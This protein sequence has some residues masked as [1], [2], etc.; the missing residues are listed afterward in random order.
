MDII[1][2][3]NGDFA[4]LMDYYFTSDSDYNVLGFCVERE[5]MQGKTFSGKPLVA[6]E[7]VEKHYPA[8]KIKMFVAIGYKSMRLRADLYKKTV[9]KGYMHV[10]YISSKCSIDKSCIVGKNNAVLQ[11]VVLEPFSIV[12][13]NNIINTRSTIC[14]HAKVGNDCFIAAHSL[15]GGY[16]IIKDNCFLGFSS[17]VLQK[18]VIERE[19]LIA[20]GAVVNK[21]SYMYQFLAGSPALVK[22]LHAKNGI[23]IN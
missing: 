1:I 17:T 22:T 3:G 16:T 7:E 23:V 20:A 14:H 11:G 19:T 9:A 18:L 15:I 10:N 2:Y 6:F 8:E 13:N 21:N 5:Y 12:G 4:E